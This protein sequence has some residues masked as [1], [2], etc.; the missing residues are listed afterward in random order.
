MAAENHIISYEG[1][2]K[3]LNGTLKS[4]V[5]V[6]SEVV[7]KYNEWVLPKIPSEYINQLNQMAKSYEKINKSQKDVIDST[8]REERARKAKA[9]ADRAEANAAKAKLLQLQAEERQRNRNSAAVDRAV[10]KALEESRAYRR[11]QDEWRKAQATYADFYTLYGR[12]NQATIK[13]RIEFDKLDKKIREVDAATKNYA[14]NVGNYSSAFNGLGNLTSQLAGVLGWAGAIATAVNIGKSIYKTTKELDILNKAMQ[15]GSKDA[16]AYASNISFLDKITEQYGLE[17]ISTSQAYNKFYIA[18]KNKLA[19]NDIQLIF[20]KISKSASLMGL[21][22]DQQKGIF[23]A[24]EQMMSKGTVQSEELRMQL[25]DR[26]PGAFEIMANAVGV[27]TSELGDMMKSGKVMAADVL[28]KFA[29]ELEKAFG[30]DKIDRIENLAAAENRATNSWTNFV[31]G[32][33]SG[34]GIISK[35]VIGFL[36]LTSGVLSA[37]TAKEKL[38]DSILKEQTELSILIGKI[39]SLNQGNSKREELINQL[40]STY[41]GFISLIENE[42]FTNAN[43]LR[44]L[45]KVNESYRDRLRLQKQVEELEKFTSVRDTYASGAIDVENQLMEKIIKIQNK[46]NHNYKISHD[47]L[48]KS[49]NDYISVFGGQMSYWELRSLKQL[50]NNVDM[51]QKSEKEY[52]SLITEQKNKIEETQKQTGKRTEAEEKSIEN[53]KNYNEALNESVIIAKKLGGKAGKDFSDMNLESVNAYIA[54]VKGIGEESEKARKKREAAEAKARKE[55]EKAEKEELDINYKIAEQKIQN[56]IAVTEDYEQQLNLR[57]QAVLLWYAYEISKAG[58]NAKQKELIKLQY[59][60]KI[61]KLDD[62]SVKDIDENNKKKTESEKKAAEKRYEIWKKV[63]DDIKA[64]AYENERFENEKS[65]LALRKELEGLNQGT[66]Q[67]YAKLLEIREAEHKY[68]KAHLEYL[69][70]VENAKEVKDP[71]K[72]KELENAL[73]T[74]DTVFDSDKFKIAKDTLS[75]FESS[76]SDIF[77]NAGFGEIA[78]LL[79]GSFLNSIKNVKDWKEA[80]SLAIQAVGAISSE[81]FAK[82]RASSDA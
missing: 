67:Y 52:N 74:L 43:L 41:P 9:D 73:K 28:P 5:S 70:A 54:K 23:L 63:S 20:D 66:P 17:L 31:D 82:M 6:M 61:R 2:V 40:K 18:S 79:D 44:T 48:V 22:V 53:I 30:A 16:N 76:L 19:L 56:G 35:T 13:A 71:L 80:A 81:I 75:S 37:V 29:I 77:I 34:N 62:D 72:I 59:D 32:L 57:R 4:H 60:G 55:R 3:N 12:Q 51:F 26:L 7:Q 33:N 69:L 8:I 78:E 45:N 11:L 14:K 50:K 58:D 64:L 15:M 25:G 24:L 27:S 21:S 36:N 49:A 38:S 47:N 1:A 39:T 42:D 46:Y 65:I 68:D 10:Q